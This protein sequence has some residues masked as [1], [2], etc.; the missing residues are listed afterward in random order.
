MS[1][2][3]ERLEL[4]RDFGELRAG[5][6]LVIKDCRW[7][8]GDHRFMAVRFSNEL[9]QLPNGELTRMP[10]WDVLPAPEHA[11]S[12]HAVTKLSVE[13]RALFRVVDGFEA[14]S[15]TTTTKRKKART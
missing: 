7:C 15:T 8:G 2:E 11:T 3:K 12:G 4:V 9:G 14:S 1:G 6:L 10:A 13:R 5:M